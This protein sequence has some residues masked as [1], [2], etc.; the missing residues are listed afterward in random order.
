MFETTWG[1]VNSDWVNYLTLPLK[2]QFLFV[3]GNGPIINL[4][5][6]MKKL[7][8]RAAFPFKAI[9]NARRSVRSDLFFSFEDQWTETFRWCHA[10]RA[11]SVWLIF[12]HKSSHTSP[13]LTPQEPKDQPPE[14]TSSH[15]T[16]HECEFLEDLRSFCVVSH[17]AASPEK[18][19]VYRRAIRVEAVSVCTGSALVQ[20]KRTIFKDHLVIYLLIKQIFQMKWLWYF[21]MF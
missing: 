20:P 7:S 19:N 13:D 2:S 21:C 12:Y 14:S 9:H 4:G 1:W 6:K 3:R 5:T 16:V 17:H 8:K 10:K 15:P 18:N 11:G